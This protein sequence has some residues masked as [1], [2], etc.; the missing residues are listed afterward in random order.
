MRLVKGNY[1]ALNEKIKHLIEKTADVS[2]EAVE[3]AIAVECMNYIAGDVPGVRGS[4]VWPGTVFDLKEGLKKIVKEDH[5]I[6]PLDPVY[7]NKP[8][9]VVM[10]HEHYPTM[11]CIKIERSKN[12]GLMVWGYNHVKG[13]PTHRTLGIRYDRFIAAGI[14]SAFRFYSE[15]QHAVDKIK[16]LTTP[17]P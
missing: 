5:C 8:I 4:P 10:G 6:D 13:F 12:A 3:F 11:A 9:W 1:D 2:A 14:N 15:H 16:D 17:E 7:F